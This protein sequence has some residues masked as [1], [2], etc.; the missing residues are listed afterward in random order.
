MGAGKV[1]TQQGRSGLNGTNTVIERCS[2]P[3]DGKMHKDIVATA[4]WHM[5]SAGDSAL[6]ITDVAAM[7]G[8]SVFHLTRAFADATGISPARY[9]RL[10]RLTRAVGLLEDGDTS[11]VEV[12]L[13]A[14]YA[15]QEA[16]TRA[17]AAT[18]GV[19]PAAARRGAQ[20]P[21]T[22]MQESITM[23]TDGQNAL[24]SPPR[25]ETVAERR[26]VGLSARYSF[27]TNGGIPSQWVAFLAEAD[28]H[29]LPLSGQ[30]F[31]VCFDASED[32]AFSYLAGVESTTRRIPMGF[33]S[34]VIPAGRYAV[35]THHGPAATLRHT[36]A[37]IWGR[38]LPN[39]AIQTA[40][41]P[42]FELYPAGYDPAA[43]GSKVEIWIPINT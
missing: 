14:G 43:P 9:L 26:I 27:E 1:E 16:F 8:V 40:G 10:R 3:K 2:T 32:G 25:Y 6:K 18:F 23:S 15:S 22:I 42:D 28:A 13:G 39:A 17:F 34:V 20:I 7:T 37:A 33:G 21:R 11:I 29:D 24:L 35:F 41:G 30:S 4:L 12:A 5:E 36:V 38:Y 19:T 31:G